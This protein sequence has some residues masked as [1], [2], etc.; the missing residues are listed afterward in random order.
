MWGEWTPT[1]DQDGQ[2]SQCST[3]CG[4]GLRPMTRSKKMMEAHG[5]TSCTGES[6][7]D[8][9]CNPDACPGV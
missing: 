5:G 1:I 6:E 7:K 9:P 4:G 3:S 2:E 8:E